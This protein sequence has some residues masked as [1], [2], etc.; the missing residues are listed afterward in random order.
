VRLRARG[1]VLEWVADEPAVS[2]SDVEE[3][4]VSE[5]PNLIAALR[6]LAALAGVDA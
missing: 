6:E 4:P 1:G 3:V 2:L 5:I